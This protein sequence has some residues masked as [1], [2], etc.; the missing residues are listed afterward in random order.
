MESIITIAIVD[1]HNIF[2]LGLDIILNSINYVKVIGD[3]ATG[4][5]LHNLLKQ[6]KPDI[7]FM[8][9][10]L[11]N[12]NGADLTKEV[13]SKY[14][15]VKIIAI[16]SSDEIKHFKEMI[17]AGAHGFLL[18]NVQEN[19]IEEAIQS[20]VNNNMYFSKEF[21]LFARQLTP[22]RNKA[23]HNIQISEREKEVLRLICQGYSN[24]KIAKEMVLSSHTIDAHRRSLLS[25]T[26]AKNTAEMI[27]I[28]FKEQ[29]I[30]PE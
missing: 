2:R 1:D 28:A 21:L 18:K 23:S 29:L 13:L 24:A 6:H 5:Q 19:I 20:V 26:G 17:D 3:V 30:N 7:I 15:D 27:M 10:N 9:V 8:D 4:N 14:T 12:E 16:T 11:E 25:K 22:A